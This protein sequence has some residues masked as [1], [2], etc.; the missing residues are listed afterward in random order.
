M[1]EVTAPVAKKRR[2][3]EPE[4]QERSEGSDLG[5]D[6]DAGG[7]DLISLLPDE[8]LG[9]IISLLPTRDAART[10]VLSPRWRHLWRSAPLNLDADGGLSGLERKR[11]SIV[12]RI[13]EAHRGPAR[14]LSLRTVRLRGIYARFDRWFRS[15]A[16]NNLEHLDFAYASD[17]RYYGT[18]VDP[19]PRPPRPLPL[20]ALRFAPTLRTAYIGGCDFPAVAPAAAPCFPRL[21]RLTLYGVAISED[22]LHHVLAGCAVL[23]TLGLEASSGFGAVRINSP[24]LRSVGF[25]VSA[26]TELVIEDAPCLER[27]MLLDPHSGP[28]NV[29]VVRAPQLKVL[30]Y[31]SDK[32]TKLDLGTVIIQETM[33]VSST[34]SLRTVKV[35]VLESAGPNLDTIIGFL[36][37]FP[38]LE[39]LYIMKTMKN[40]RRYNP[41]E[42]I[43][44]L[45]HHLRYIILNNYLGMRPDVNFAKLFVLKAR[46]L[47]AMKFGVL[48]GCTEKSMANQHSRLQLDHKASPDA[49]FDFRRDYCWRN[50]L[51]NKRTH[52][53]PRDDPF[54]GSIC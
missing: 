14:R 20:S 1:E 42:P 39:K 5:G 54:D 28:K 52:D 37:C 6:A 38:C 23:E 41:L 53:L 34:A 27:L 10:T 43:E 48:V 21:T 24:T 30:G 50:I 2:Q 19:D 18:G 13:L 7:I 31:L 47:K 22:A 49:Q 46:M 29:R 25:A 4:C 15:A 45:D 26:E 36:K 17:G 35:L 32:I 44:C 16:L 51:Y 8:I 9:S 40:T 33:V 11:I 3:D 12:S